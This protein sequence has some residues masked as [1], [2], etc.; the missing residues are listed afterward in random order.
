MAKKVHTGE[1][2]T[3]TQQTLKSAIRGKIFSQSELMRDNLVGGT[4]FLHSTKYPTQVLNIKGQKYIRINA[5]DIHEDTIDGL[6]SAML[7]FDELKIETEEGE[8][9]AEE[10]INKAVEEAI[11]E[12]IKKN[13]E[14]D[15]IDLFEEEMFEKDQ[16][17][18]LIIEKIPIQPQMRKAK[19]TKE[20]KEEE[21]DKA[22]DEAKEDGESCDMTSDAKQMQE[23]ID[24]YDSDDTKPAEEI[25]Y[26]AVEE[27]EQSLNEIS[28]M[29]THSSVFT[30]NYSIL[31]LEDLKQLYKK[32]PRLL[33]AFQG[34]GGKIKKI[35]PSKRINSKAMA[36]DRDKVYW[37]KQDNNGKHI[38]LNFLIDMSGSM[39]GEPVKN[40][41]RIV[42]LFNQLAK[43]GYL[44][45]SVIYS[46]TRDSH[47]LT[48]PCKDAELLSL[49]GVTGS[50]GLAET[51]RRWQNDIKNTNLI[52]LT[53]GDIVDEPI[54]KSFWAKNKIVS[55]GIY[56]NS[57]AK[58]VLA[59]SGNLSKWF[60][61]S[62]VRQNVDDLIE[63]LIKTGLKG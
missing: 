49:N 50:E 8:E 4:E 25:Q 38:K 43:A 22:E 36:M 1:V 35:T 11:M 51:V 15:G 57:S 18:N 20:E 23:V 52:C 17:D 30:N 44:S 26:A 2:L 53:D 28:D 37:V 32:V 59:Y 34:R 3:E 47:K 13:S 60:D 42:W 21:E 58:D 10:D 6:L 56:V 5:N 16:Y 9:P 48:L 41:V 31:S 7:G 62:I 33:K 46:S 55:T 63:W 54:N 40:A 29:D 61:H 24:S 19:A 39:H 45:M 14:Q 27:L 12:S